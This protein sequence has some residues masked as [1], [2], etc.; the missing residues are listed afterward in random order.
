LA[1]GLVVAWFQGRSESGPRA[2]GNRSILANPMVAGLK[3]RLNA[4]I[5]FREDFRPYGCSVLQECAHEYF[6][7]EKGFNNPYM[8]F[9]VKTRE[10]QRR[11]LSQVT[12]IDGSSRMQT[13]GKAQNP[14][15]YE[16]I[17]AFGEKT[18]LNCLLN[19]SLNIMGEPIVETAEDARKFLLAT[20]VD[21]M[22]IGRF[23]IQK[24]AAR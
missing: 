6:E 10:N 20:P 8:S 1:K 12:H 18:G 17:K 13:V 24:R 5:K 21:G 2:L 16:L 22:A 11:R 14:L 3:D 15:F 4:E 19:T 23:Y 7:V 9:A